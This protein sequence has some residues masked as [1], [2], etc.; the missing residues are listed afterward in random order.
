[1]IN[2]DVIWSLSLCQQLKVVTVVRN[3]HGIYFGE[4][5][6]FA[7][8]SFVDNHGQNEKFW[9]RNSE[10]S[11]SFGNDKISDIKRWNARY[12]RKK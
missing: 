9:G 1:M 8:F 2:L 5:T 7:E 11:Y 3:F 12:H 4:I 6:E 10:K